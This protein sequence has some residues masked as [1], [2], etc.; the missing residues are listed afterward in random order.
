[1]QQLTKEEELPNG[2]RC[3]KGE[4]W[5]DC[6]TQEHCRKPEPTLVIIHRH[7]AYL[8]DT[9]EVG[10]SCIPPFETPETH[11]LEGEREVLEEKVKEKQ[12]KRI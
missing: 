8:T 6:I 11:F 7:Q 1:M 10:W 3:A 9:G 5:S 4:L 12:A 2:K